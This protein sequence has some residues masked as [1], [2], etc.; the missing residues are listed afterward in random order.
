MC[1][2]KEEWE[3]IQVAKQCFLYAAVSF[4]CFVILTGYYRI[5]S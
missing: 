3:S 1:L 5:L 2:M 4:S